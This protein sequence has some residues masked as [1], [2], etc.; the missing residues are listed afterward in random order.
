MITYG[1]TLINNGNVTMTGVSVEDTGPTVGTG[2]MPA[3]SCEWPGVISVISPQDTPVKYTATYA[4]SAGNIS[5][6][7]NLATY[8]PSTS[9]IIQPRSVLPLAQLHNS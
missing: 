9:K 5:T 2:N 7:N 1:Y 4:L 3:V 8:T 6:N